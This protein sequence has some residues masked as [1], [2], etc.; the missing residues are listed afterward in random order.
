MLKKYGGFGIHISIG[1]LLKEMPTN[2]RS[3]TFGWGEI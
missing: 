3:L 1:M 2:E